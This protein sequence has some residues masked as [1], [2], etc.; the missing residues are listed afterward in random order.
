L[1]RKILV[2]LDG[3]KLAE[4][5]LP[6]AEMLAKYACDPPPYVVLLMVCEPLAVS[7]DLP[8]VSMPANWEKNVQHVKN[9]T[10]KAAHRYL[11]T[12]QSK[13][14]ES[15]VE[16]RTEVLTGDPASEIIKYANDNKFNL[17]IMST[18][19]RSGVKRLA[20]GSVTN[21]VLHGL[22]IPIFLVKEKMK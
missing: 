4:A 13:L 19:G 7:A 11:S 20:L 17:L 6:H 3:S 18:H 14:R 21:K 1:Y 16:V 2:T 12:V 9:E 5:A 22:S 10:V 15:G 8:G